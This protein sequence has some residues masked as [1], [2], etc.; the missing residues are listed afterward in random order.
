[1]KARRISTIIGLVLLLPVNLVADTASLQLRLQQITAPDW[2]AEGAD[3]RV[4]YANQ[5]PVIRLTLANLWLPGWVEPVADLVFNCGSATTGGG[6]LTCQSEPGQFIVTATGSPQLVTPELGFSLDWSSGQVIKSTL[7]IGVDQLN[8]E[9]AL[10]LFPESMTEPL[11]ERVAITAAKISGNLQVSARGANQVTVEGNAEIN[12][13]SFSDEMGTRAGEELAAQ[14]GFSGQARGNE[15][16]FRASSQLT[17]GALFINPWFFSWSDRGPKL[18]VSGRWLADARQL[19]VNAR[20]QHPDQFELAGGAIVDWLSPQPRLMS[21]FGRLTVESLAATYQGYLQPWLVNTLGGDLQADGQI[22]ARFAYTGEQGLTSLGL[23]LSDVSVVDQQSRFS[24]AGLS[25]SLP[26]RGKNRPGSGQMRWDE[27]RLYRLPVGAGSGDMR[28]DQSRLEFDISPLALFDG[29][30]S[31]GKVAIQGL[32]TDQLAITLGG[33]L[34]P[35]SLPLITAALG[36]PEMVGSLSAR[37][38][39]IHYSR[40]RIELEGGVA[41]NV[42]D[43][44]LAMSNLVIEDVFGRVPRLSA[45]LRGDNLDLALLTHTF[46]FGTITGRVSG[47]VQ[48]L[49]LEAWQPVAFDGWLQTPADDPGRH[50]ISQRALDSLSS[51]G[52]ISGALQSTL[53]RFF[54]DFSY[55]RLGIGC[56]LA[57]G[58]CTMRGIANNGPNKNDSYYI[59][60]GGGW[61]PRIDLVGYN[62]RVNWSVLIQRL[63]AATAV[64]EIEIR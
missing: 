21:T 37:I 10:A 1:M 62:R 63:T 38:P 12:G 3:L 50:R 46:D 16:T 39:A 55:R 45:D 30:F 17:G 19:T 41:I 40:S 51:I 13:L 5:H 36:W 44:E 47:Q 60:E 32:G 23:E 56:R 49:E 58:V 11:R 6:L 53:L 35:V 25:A 57:N 7:S 59:V 4:T 52:G 9:T 34:K 24:I 54:D 42:F 48:G 18:A 14:I 15:L 29:E 2:R 31:A 8:S 61:W 27:L 22:S 43:G 28:F 33:E 20:Y 64:D 26:W